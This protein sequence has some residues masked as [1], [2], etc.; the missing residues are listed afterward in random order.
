MK[1]TTLALLI[2]GLGGPIGFAYGD[3]A[4]TKKPATK[5]A[6]AEK[7]TYLGV[8]VEALPPALSSQ[9]S[10]IVP[11]GEGVLIMQVAQNSP[12]AKAG[13]KEDDILL[14]FG[15]EKVNSPEQ[16]VK[17]VR[18]DKPGKE[19]KLGLVRGGKAETCKAMLGE[20]EVPNMI[21]KPHVFRVTP[22]DLQQGLLD[23]LNSN[24]GESV[25]QSFNALKLTRLDNKRSRRK[26]TTATRR[27]RTST[28]ALKEPAPKLVSAYRPRRTCRPPSSNA[29]SEPSI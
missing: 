16:L 17:L 22:G 25:W 10:G 9:L 13:V 23:D 2:C 11:K 27:A 1:K 12:A 19:V 29:S 14:T 15:D 21:E 28:R 24:K 18:G 26:S 3:D 20:R 6:A 7:L 4:P 5:Q 8:G